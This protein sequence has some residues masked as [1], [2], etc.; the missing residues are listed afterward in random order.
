MDRRIFLHTPQRRLLEKEFCVSG[1][2]VSDALNFHRF[3]KR[4]S[5]DVVACNNHNADAVFLRIPEYF[6]S[7][8]LNIVVIIVFLKL[9]IK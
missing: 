4:S 7:S 5:L 9:H 6:V 3:N 8:L 1:A 2:T